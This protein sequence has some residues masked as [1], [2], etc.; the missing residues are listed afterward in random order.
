MLV[1][2]STINIVKETF[3]KIKYFKIKPGTEVKKKLQLET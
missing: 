2:K 1:S 3:V